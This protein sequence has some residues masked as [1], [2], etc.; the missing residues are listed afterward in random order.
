M[1]PTAI[2][3]TPGPCASPRSNTPVKRIH[4]AA[5][6]EKG[7]NPESIRQPISHRTAVTGILR[8]RPPSSRMSRM[9]VA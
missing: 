2:A 1:P 5:K 7:G 8:A 3:T 4:S 9:R 6:L